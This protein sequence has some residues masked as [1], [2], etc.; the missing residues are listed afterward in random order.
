M[1]IGSTFMA[2]LVSMCCANPLI[3]S[4]PKKSGPAPIT[5][6]NIP[7]L[8]FFRDGKKYFS[9]VQDRNSGD[10]LLNTTSLRGGLPRGDVNENILCS[11]LSYLC[12]REEFGVRA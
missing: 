11:A 2:S 10:P 4:Y 8:Q 1:A 12:W 6:F 3:G 7:T 9:E 5:D